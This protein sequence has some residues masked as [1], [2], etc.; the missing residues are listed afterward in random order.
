MPINKVACP[1]CGAGLSSKAG[2]DVGDEIECPKCGEEFTVRAPKPA[3]K[4][5]AKPA[6]I[7][8]AKARPAPRDDDDDEEDERPKKKKKPAPRDDDDERPKKKKKKGKKNSDSEGSYKTSPVRFIVLG[9][10]VLVMVV[11]GVLLFLKKSGEASAILS[12][13]F[14]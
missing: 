13:S 2:F 8:A 1:E 5:V 12:N 10:L 6:P 7:P 9:I 3:A 14:A 4:P 11:L